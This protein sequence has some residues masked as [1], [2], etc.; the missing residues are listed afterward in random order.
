MLDA[1]DDARA[2]RAVAMDAAVDA[3][4]APRFRSGAATRR[5][6]ARGIDELLPRRERGSSS[7]RNELNER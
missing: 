3:S 2:P 6:R 4:A 7:S 5:T 1:A